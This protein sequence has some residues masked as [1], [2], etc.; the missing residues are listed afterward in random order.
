[1]NAFPLVSICIPAYNRPQWL[2]RALTSI[3]AVDP[4]LCQE[5]EIII[6]DDSTDPICGKITQEILNKWQ[7]KGQYIANSPRLGMAKN[8]NHSIQLASGKYIVVLHDDDY[9]VKNGVEN[10]LNTLK[11]LTEKHPVLLFGVQVVNEKEKILKTQTVSETQYLSPKEAL[12]NLLSNSSFVRFP[13]IAIQRNIFEEVGYFNHKWGEPTDIDMW[14]RLFSCYGVYC[15]PLIT[16]AYTVHSQALTM[17]VFN[18]NTVTTLLGF[19]ER[20]SSLNILSPSELKNCQRQFFHQFI[21]AG[22][23]RMLRRGKL[24]DFDQVMQLFKLPTIK[25]LNPPKK[26]LLIRFIFRTI[27]QLYIIMNR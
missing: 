26:W 14:I 15:V 3:T 9:F 7:G 24:R 13:A 18:E 23:F 27:D 19:F 4:Q 10:L 21:L 25:D 2:K 17:G 1:M 22:A 5:I 12:I 6:S 11:S 8:W 16:C 20:V